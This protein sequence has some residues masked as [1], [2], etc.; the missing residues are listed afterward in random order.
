MISQ[1]GPKGRRPPHLRRPGR[2]ALVRRGTL[3]LLLL[4]F[5]VLPALPALALHPGAS[6]P[7]GPSIAAERAPSTAAPVADL[8]HPASSASPLAALRAIPAA[9]T[10]YPYG[11]ADFGITSLASNGT[12]YSYASD[13]FLG[14]MT[15]RSL[16]ATALIS[17]GGNTYRIDGA[18]IQ[19][20]TVLILQKGSTNYSYWV[21]NVPFVSP[22]GN[23]I[24]VEDN[25]WN[26]STSGT[27]PAGSIVGNGQIDAL[28]STE[29]VYI[30][31]ASPFLPGNNVSL[32]Y[33]ATVSALLVTGDAG[34]VPYV[35]FEYRDGFGWQSYDNIS[36][37]WAT[38]G[39]GWA[40][41]G[42]V[43]DGFARAPNGVYYDAEWVYCGPGDGIAST[44]LASNI[45]MSLQYDNGHNFQA[46][47]YAL[48]IG[49]DT[50]ERMYNV[51]DTPGLALGDGTPS[52][53]LTVGNSAPG[54][55][56]TASQTATVNVTSFLSSG[57]LSFG[58]SNVTYTG[59]EANVTL[60]PGTYEVVLWN[61]TEAVAW[62]NVTLSPGEY[63]PLTLTPAPLTHPVDLVATGL[64]AKVG[65]SIVIGATPYLSAGGTIAL[66]LLDGTYDYRIVPVPGYTVPSYQGS[67]TVSGR[68]V[69]LTVTWSPF[70]APLTVNV[71]GLPATT[72]WTLTVDPGSANSTSG[73]GAIVVDLANGTYVVNVSAPYYYLTTEGSDPVT[74]TG[75]PQSFTVAFGIRYA[76]LVGAVHP[77]NATVTLNGTPL[78]VDGAGYFFASLGA[79]Q[80]VINASAPGYQSV[81]Y[82]E[83]FSPG[84][85]TTVNYTLER[86]SGGVSPPPPSSNATPAGGMGSGSWELLAGVA[87]VGA[88]IVG[89]VAAL[90]RRRPPK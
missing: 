64:P 67:F 44:N 23:T 37:P 30:A 85:T 8:A 61:G 53:T 12:A 24:T 14:T 72:N 6:A 3:A 49:A 54:M 52:G 66:D 41:L 25:V 20:N 34:G 87:L 13:A 19:L 79:G 15:I 43:V 75:S 2:P 78:S 90:A 16:D 58:G 59:S 28:S 4:A 68:S 83:P 29:D 27:I 5:L 74:M 38:A 21:Q 69:N 35:N 60:A 18:S 31:Q 88:A 76:H 70:L 81:T 22:P 73:T 57:N 11:V 84:N 39:G 45:T 48:N 77:A 42:F 51:T 86:L 56:Y 71:S 55:L 65:W 63:L 26:L 1:D 10:P 9:N 40:D 82:V 80:Y 17:Y 32:A 36:F 33:P 47:P 62:A 46:V 89:V 7:F 50:G